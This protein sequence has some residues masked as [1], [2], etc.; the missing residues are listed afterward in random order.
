MVHG[1][2]EANHE[3]H[4]T[5]SILLHPLLAFDLLCGVPSLAR[6]FIKTLEQEDLV[7]DPSSSIKVV[8]DIQAG[9]ALH[10]LETLS[11]KG[12]CIIVITFSFCPEYWDDLWDLHPDVLTVASALERDFVGTVR[13]AALG[14]RYRIVP[15]FKTALSKTERDV[16]CHLARGWSNKKIALHLGLQEK[17]VLNTL[18]SVYDKLHLHNRTEAL[19]YYWGISNDVYIL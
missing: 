19:L 9:F 15:K 5:S 12:L 11:G 2:N 16:L 17:T 7:Y 8:I 4:T 10:V 3:L 6:S 13:R 14:E 1:S 18:T